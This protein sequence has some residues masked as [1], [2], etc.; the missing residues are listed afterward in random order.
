MLIAD[1]P[2]TETAFFARFG[3]DL[4]CRAYLF[5]LRW[6]TGFRCERCQDQN[7]YAHKKRIIDECKSC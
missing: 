4:A 7:C 3:T 1:F 6:P 2:A 5:G